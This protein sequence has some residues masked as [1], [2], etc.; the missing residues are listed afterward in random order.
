MTFQCRCKLLCSVR[1]TKVIEVV[2]KAQNHRQSTELVLFNGIQLNPA[3][4]PSPCYYGH[5]NITYHLLI[6]S[7]VI[8]EK[9]QTKALM[10]EPKQAWQCDLSVF[11]NIVP[12]YFVPIFYSFFFAHALVALIHNLKKSC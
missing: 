10:Y 6:K 12:L 5:L 4:P 11:E 8:I 9:S 7:E 1:C 3:L 2:N